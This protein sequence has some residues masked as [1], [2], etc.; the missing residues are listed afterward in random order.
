MLS[1]PLSASAHDSAKPPSTT[2]LQPLT[3]QVEPVPAAPIVADPATTITPLGSLS[4]GATT[5]Q[6]TSRLPTPTD[7]PI[8]MAV[9]VR[10]GSG[11]GELSPILAQLGTPKPTV[12]P[13]AP[14]A[15]PTLQPLQVSPVQPLPVASSPK[16]PASSSQNQPAAVPQP[17]AVAGVA[18]PPQ[19]PA[20]AFPTPA[21]LPPVATLP[22]PAA[23]AHDNASTPWI[24]GLFGLMAVLL[25][26]TVLL[27]RRRL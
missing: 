25:L 17:G 24:I 18:A 7:A 15:S 4:V 6:A 23:S 20:A 27:A 9:I 22:A 16:A 10:L 13:S 1:T 5:P 2:S 19:L 11:P 8:G 14:K 3:V 12:P 21:L 26:S